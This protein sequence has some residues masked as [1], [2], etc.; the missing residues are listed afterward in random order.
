MY[1]CT[2]VH[3][4]ATEQIWNSKQQ[5]KTTTSQRMYVGVFAPSCTFGSLLLY[6]SETRAEQLELKLK[7]HIQRPQPLDVQDKPGEVCVPLLAVGAAASA[8]ARGIGRVFKHL[9]F[10]RWRGCGQI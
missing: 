4:F 6:F 7:T 5:N 1:V 2:Y 10:G 9:G 8:C 3:M